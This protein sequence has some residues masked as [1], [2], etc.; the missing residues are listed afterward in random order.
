[1]ARLL[2]YVMLL[3]PVL[4]CDH[5]AQA[6]ECYPRCTGTGWTLY[7]NDNVLSRPAGGLTKEE[8]EEFQSEILSQRPPRSR[9]ECVE[10]EIARQQS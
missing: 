8:C 6:E 9:L 10:E 7:L 2:V 5:T 3:T 4:G 1:V